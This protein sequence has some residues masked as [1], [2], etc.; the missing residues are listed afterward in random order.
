MIETK[1]NNM[2]VKIKDDDTMNLTYLYYIFTYMHP[3]KTAVC[4]SLKP[5]VQKCF[6]IKIKLFAILLTSDGD[7]SELQ[8]VCLLSCRKAFN[9]FTQLHGP[10]LYSVKQ[11][12]YHHWDNG[13]ET[14]TKLLSK[15][16]KSSLGD[17]FRSN[18]V[19]ASPQRI[20]ICIFRAFAK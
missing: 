19:Y 13:K 20:K 16:T 14:V 10:I 5:H 3:C 8:F 6:M 1:V 18:L 7:C 4:D 15:A 11:W 17:K 12:D 9:L 2:S